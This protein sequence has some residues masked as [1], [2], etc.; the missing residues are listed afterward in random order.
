MQKA[1][2]FNVTNKDSNIY[3]IH[4]VGFNISIR[5]FYGRSL[6]FMPAKLIVKGIISEFFPFAV[7]CQRKKSNIMNYKLMHL[8][9]IV[10]KILFNFLL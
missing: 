3:F 6:V 10:L 9:Q 1:L 8:I 4:G 5:S 7:L 2:N